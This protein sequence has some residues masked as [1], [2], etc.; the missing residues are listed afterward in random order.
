MKAKNEKITQLQ[1]SCM[2]S[3]EIITNFCQDDIKTSRLKQ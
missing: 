1:T 3:I 2:K